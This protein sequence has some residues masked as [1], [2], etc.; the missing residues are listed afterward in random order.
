MFKNLMKA[1]I[2]VATL[3]V[4]VAADVVTLGGTLADSNESYTGKKISD[5][6]KNIDKAVDPDEPD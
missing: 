2:G 1:A 5:V 3:P 4:D 6:L